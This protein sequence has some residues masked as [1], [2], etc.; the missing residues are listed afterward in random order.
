M[1]DTTKTNVSTPIDQGRAVAA[2][3][4]TQVA[5][6]AG[7]AKEQVAS[8]ADESRRHAIAAVSTASKEVETQ[9]DGRLESAA[10]VARTTSRQLRALAEGRGDDA[11]PMLDLAQDLSTRL[12]RFAERGEQLGVRG[13][14]EELTDL[15]RRRPVAFLAGSVA[16]GVLVGRLARAGSGE[17][18]G[19]GSDR[20][21]SPAAAGATSVGGTISGQSTAPDGRPADVV[22]T[23]EQE[24]VP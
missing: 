8:L 24:L 9:L 2:E 18:H 19:S 5:E 17:A 1:T 15:A 20:S 23:P 11:G 13:I 6:V 12:E 14:A 21:T 10:E 16:V 4:G 7:H 22:A 3:A